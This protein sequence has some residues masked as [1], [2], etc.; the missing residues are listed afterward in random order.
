M[1]P[2]FWRPVPDSGLLCDA[3]HHGRPDV[4]HLGGTFYSNHD[5]VLQGCHFPFQGGG[6]LE[7]RTL[8]F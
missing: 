7:G 5:R 8:A 2:T 6:R 3:P 4:H 1:S